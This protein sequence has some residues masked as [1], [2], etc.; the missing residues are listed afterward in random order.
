MNLR[1]HRQQMQNAAAEKDDDA[2]MARASENDASS[3]LIDGDPLSSRANRTR[4]PRV[5]VDAANVN[6][7]A[8]RRC[9]F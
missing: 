3:T 6:L 5:R 1:R 8:D 9:H 4:L 2:S 7:H